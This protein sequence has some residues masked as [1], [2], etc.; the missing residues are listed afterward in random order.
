M[1]TK[2]SLMGYPYRFTEMRNPNDF[3]DKHAQGLEVVHSDVHF[4][5][6][7]TGVPVDPNAV[8]EAVADIIGQPI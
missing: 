4:E 2:S 6:E 1:K 3:L 5:G 8:V 7:V